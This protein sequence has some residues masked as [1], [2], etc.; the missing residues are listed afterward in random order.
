MSHQYR[1]RDIG[2]ERYLTTH[3][4]RSILEHDGFNVKAVYGFG[5]KETKNPRL[6]PKVL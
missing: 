5:C 2:D 3:K 6:F 1:R 4:W